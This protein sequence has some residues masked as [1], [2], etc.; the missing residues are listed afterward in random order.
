MMLS[1]PAISFSIPWVAFS[2]PPIFT[3]IL[4]SLT[5]EERV[6]NRKEAFAFLGWGAGKFCLWHA[7]DP[8]KRFLRNSG[9]HPCAGMKIATLEMKLVLPLMLL[10]CDYELVDGS[11]KYPQVLPQPD[12]NDLHQVCCLVAAPK[13][14][15]NWSLCLG[16]PTAVL[17]EVQTCED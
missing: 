15:L 7:M 4:P 14:C 12:R 3:W 5:V 16:S 17:S 6:E 11:G 2:F 9:R 8:W 1:T 13:G 10:G